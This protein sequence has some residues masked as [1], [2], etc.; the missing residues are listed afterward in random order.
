MCKN[1]FMAALTVPA[2]DWKRE[3]S[4]YTDIERASKYHH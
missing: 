4:I 2:K 1:V 3:S